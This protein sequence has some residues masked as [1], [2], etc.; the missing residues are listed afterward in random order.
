[1]RQITCMCTLE[2]DSE[3]KA[4]YQST[5]CSQILLQGFLE[6]NY[7][8]WGWEFSMKPCITLRQLW[9]NPENDADMLRHQ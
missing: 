6:P 1:M 9:S 5:H 2:S 8:R 7:S 4:C 3:R